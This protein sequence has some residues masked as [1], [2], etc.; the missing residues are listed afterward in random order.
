MQ[1]AD[2]QPRLRRG[3]TGFGLAFREA[4]RKEGW[5]GAEQDDIRAG[6][7]AAIE[8]GIVPAGNVAITGTSS[9]LPPSISSL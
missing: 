7:E 3:S 4:I 6:A 2:R 1:L 8:R 9:G 5:G